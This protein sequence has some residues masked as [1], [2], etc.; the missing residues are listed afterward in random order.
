MGPSLLLH[1]AMCSECTGLV[2]VVR[3]SFADGS[4]Q[5]CGDTVPVSDLCIQIVYLSGGDRWC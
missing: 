5:R 3:P 2:V 4:Q 1:S